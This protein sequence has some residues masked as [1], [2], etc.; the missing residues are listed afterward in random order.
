MKE[1]EFYS[2]FVDLINFA[3]NHTIATV[4]IGVLAVAV[5]AV[6]TIK[7]HPQL[8]NDV[9]QFFHT[10]KTEEN[11]QMKI[12]DIKKMQLEY[13]KKLENIET[14]LKEDVLDRKKR[15]EEYDKRFSAIET[16][17]EKLFSIVASH[18]EFQMKISQGTLTNMVLNDNA[19][20]SIFLRLK[21]Y[22][23]LIAMAVNGRVKKKGFELI[24]NHKE[25]WLDV[26]ET[27]PH[28]NLVIVNQKFFDATLEDINRK[29]FDGMMW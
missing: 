15:Q 14:L 2:F 1:T 8:L 18:E 17:I 28:M 4:I 23:R 24:L 13:E 11:K 9:L 16:G 6:L 29:I 12:K 22:L 20:D 19:P 27:M 10:G 3:K 25:C 21:S 5:T 7:K 26:L